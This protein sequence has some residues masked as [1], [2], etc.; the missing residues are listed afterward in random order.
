[1]HHE[2]AL[3]P[4][5]VNDFKTFKNLIDQ[6]G[7]Q[8]GRLISG[9]PSDWIKKVAEVCKLPPVKRKTIFEKT[10]RNIKKIMVSSAREYNRGTDWL[11]NAEQQHEIKP[12]HAIISLENPRNHEKIIIAEEIDST[13]D[14]WHVPRE[15]IVPRKAQDL[16]LCAK[17]LLNESRDILLVDRNFNPELPRFVNTLNILINYALEK[18]HQPRR[19]ELHVEY[20]ESKK[21]ISPPKEMWAERCHGNLSGCL[22][23]NAQLMIFR[24]RR[25]DDGDKLHPRY[26]LTEHGGIRFEYGLDEWEG[27]GQTTDVSLL[28]QSVYEQRWREYQQETAAFDLVDEIV[29]TGIKES[30]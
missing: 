20:K 8:H 12:F 3:N 15:K 29:I 6:C 14:L 28:G 11:R 9:F 5:C 10:L 16:A 25:K 4:E 7:F 21:E 23:E 22:P 13:N 1:M 24:W 27:E 19:L 30:L 17:K 18:H 2:Y 26:V